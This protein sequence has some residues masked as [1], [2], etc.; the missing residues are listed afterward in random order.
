M[1]LIDRRRFGRLAIALGVG[2][3][4]LPGSVKL[5]DTM[6]TAVTRRKL[7]AAVAMAATADKIIYEGAYGKRDSTSGVDVTTASIFRIASMTKAVTTV[8]ALQLVEQ[9]KLT[10]DEPVAKHL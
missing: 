6:R 2:A 10:L 7:P 5:D 1:F 3:R 4:K 8:A 9:G